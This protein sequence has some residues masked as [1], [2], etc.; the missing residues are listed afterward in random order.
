MMSFSYQVCKAIIFAACITYCAVT[1]ANAFGNDEYWVSGWG[2]GTKE[3]VITRGPGNEIYVA[4]EEGS[5]T[6]SSIRFMLGGD[7]ASG[8]NVTLTFEGADPEDFWIADGQITSDCHACAAN[9]DRTVEL[10]KSH[11]SV[12][13]R[14]ENGLSARFSLRG[15]SKAIGECVAGFYR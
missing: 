10:L 11:A 9:F 4:C 6:S 2:M 8:S 15:S 7:G 3:A 13:V 5:L 1:S 14:F 12:H